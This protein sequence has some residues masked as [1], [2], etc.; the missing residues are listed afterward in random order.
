[1]EKS[2]FKFSDAS[3][4][5]EITLLIPRPEDGGFAFIFPASAGALPTLAAFLEK[6]LIAESNLPPDEAERATAAIT[7]RL[8]QLTERKL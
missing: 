2:S 6:T 3:N 8:R 1:V 5:T 4:R 7:E